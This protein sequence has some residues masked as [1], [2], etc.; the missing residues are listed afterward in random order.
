MDEKRGNKQIQTVI[1][2]ETSFQGRITSTENIQIDGKQEGEIS[3]KGT[4]IISESGEGQGTVEADNMFIAGA[5]Q[6]EAKINRKLEIFA[7]GKFQGVAEMAI[8]IVEEGAGF[9]G[10]C[11]QNKK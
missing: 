11:Q 6:G 7:T 2:K 8:F 1:G 3:T 4:V 10:S 9:H 5:L